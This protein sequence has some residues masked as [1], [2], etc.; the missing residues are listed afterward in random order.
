MLTLA[1]PLS[2]NSDEI[3]FG[4]DH[5]TIYTGSAR[6]ISADDQMSGRLH[7]QWTIDT[8]LTT[9]DRRFKT[10]IS[11]LRRS[12]GKDGD[13]DSAKRIIEQL[14]PVSFI[15]TDDEEKRERFGFIAQV[16]Q[17]NVMAFPCFHLGT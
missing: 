10:D 1:S 15:L 13:E 9:S 7:G 14:R 5:F 16:C 12:L 2:I 6:I 8:A 17:T 4:L 11:P 3:R